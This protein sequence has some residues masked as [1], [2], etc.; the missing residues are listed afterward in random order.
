MAEK[1]VVGIDLGGTKIY[2]ALADLKGRLL[3]EV[4]VPTGASGG[5]KQVL[6]RMTE[7]VKTVQGQAGVSGQPLCIGVGAPGMVDAQRGFIFFA[8]N[9]GW[10]DVPLAEL[11]E[12]ELA[13]PVRLDNDANL[14]ALGENVYGAGQGTT[15]MIYVTVSTGVG[16]GLIL[17]GNL[18]QGAAGGAGE[19]GHMILEPD[20]PQ[21]TCGSRGCLEALSSGTA[22]ARRAV[23]LVEA[24]HGRAVLALAGG[25]KKRIT[26]R[27]VARAAAD[28]D[29]EAAEI[30]GSAARYLGIG[31]VNLVNLLHPELIVLGGG[32]MQIGEPIW[33]GIRREIDSRALEVAKKKLRLAPARLGA[34]AGV[35][36]AA[37]LACNAII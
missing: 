6:G 25:E 8:P 29:P 9:L 28:G 20:G 26:S 16:G 32:V 5:M 10:H 13:V 17:N 4:Q 11:M 15:E 21:C 22:M 27:T 14:A 36:G 19:I 7:T 1:Y 30:I 31:L 23:E 18:Y 35:M 37:A 24:G 12:K 34:R 3:A 33:S 2:T